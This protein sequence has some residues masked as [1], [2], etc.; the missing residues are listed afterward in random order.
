MQIEMSRGITCD[1][2]NAFYS[3]ESRASIHV[4]HLVRVR[5]VIDVRC[6]CLFFSIGV[7]S[8]L[9]IPFASLK[10]RMKVGRFN[11]RGGMAGVRDGRERFNTTTRSD[12]F[13]V[14]I[15][16]QEEVTLFGYTW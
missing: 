5:W 14:T 8:I 2:S 1:N 3:D 4:W 15:D 10:W 6:G 16:I 12:E 7:P 13:V 9:A 11:L